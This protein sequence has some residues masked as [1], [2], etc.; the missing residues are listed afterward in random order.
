M[1]WLISPERDDQLPLGV[2]KVGGGPHPFVWTKEASVRN[3]A[4]WAE[5]TLAP[6]EEGMGCP[7]LSSGGR[8]P[9]RVEA[10]YVWID[11]CKYDRREKL[12]TYLHEDLW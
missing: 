9:G 12:N 3:L 5:E 10:T 6:H 11:E 1:Q 4:E 8:Y 7:D 2:D